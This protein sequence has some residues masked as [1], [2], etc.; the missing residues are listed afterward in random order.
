M[1]NKHPIGSNWNYT[2]A[3][4]YKKELVLFFTQAIA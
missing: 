2:A 3:K 4:P 1:N